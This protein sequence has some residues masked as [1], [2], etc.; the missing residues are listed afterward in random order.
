MADR[1]TTCHSFPELIEEL[2]GA[3]R[4]GC[5]LLAASPDPQLG[6][7]VGFKLSDGTI[8]RLTLAKV[9]QFGED[10]SADPTLRGLWESIATTDGRIKLFM[11]C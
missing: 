11:T 8:Y 5:R 7:A 1:I 4:R 10:P 2:Q 3:K 6:Q 9:T